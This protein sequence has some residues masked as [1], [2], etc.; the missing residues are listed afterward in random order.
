MFYNTPAATCKSSNSLTAASTANVRE[1]WAAESARIGSNWHSL[2]ELH[3][4]IVDRLRSNS[5]SWRSS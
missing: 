4:S 2:F 5:S 1:W 3:C